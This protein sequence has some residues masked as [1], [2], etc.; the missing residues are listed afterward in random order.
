[1]ELKGIDVSKY[2]GKVDWAAIK[3]SGKVHFAILRAGYGKLASQKDTQFEANYKGAKAQ[4]IP[5]GAYWYSYA[6]TV[7]EAKQEAQAF[8]K[9]IQGKQFEY[10]VY[11]DQEY[12][13]GIKALTNTQRTAICKTFC[14]EMEKA[15]Y[16][17]GIYC[18][19]DWMNS[20]LNSSALSKYD[21]WAA[22]YASKC[23]SKH[24]Y[25]MWQYSSS[26]ALG[27]PGFDKSLDC[28][29]C[30]KDYPTI[31]KTAGLN[32]YSKDSYKVNLPAMSKA[33]AEDFKRLAESKSMSCT[34]TKA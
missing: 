18:S 4:G 30:Y 27:V 6:T 24:F 14:D 2:Q 9:V 29:I 3:K 5:V 33:N 1:M 26:N 10:P 15:G 34:L 28:N 22:Q 17:C 16:Y 12:E 11:F 21:H 31:I 25:G 20:W 8:L 32:G 23:T 13:P 19:S 7:A